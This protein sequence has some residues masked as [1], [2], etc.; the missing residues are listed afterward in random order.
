MPRRGGMRALA[1]LA[2]VT[3]PLPVMAQGVSG[4]PLGQAI[5]DD[6]GRAGV[7][8]GGREA[9]CLVKYKDGVVQSWVP[10]ETLKSAPSTMVGDESTRSGGPASGTQTGGFGVT[11]L[12]PQA[13]NHLVYRADALGHILLTARANGAPVKFLVDT[14]AT[15]VSLTTE[16]AEAAGLKRSELTFDQIVY[17][18]NGPVH[19]AFT[20]LRELK[21]DDLE[22]DDVQVAVIDSLKQSVLGMSFLRRLKEFNIRDGVLTLTW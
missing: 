10:S 2:V 17:T 21:I 11:V 12:R 20:Q 13:L 15:L 9:L 3:T 7:I 8:A 19:A 6:S 1:A 4:C 16:D 18:G 14:G 22:V 5:V